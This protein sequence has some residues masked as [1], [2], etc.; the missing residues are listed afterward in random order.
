[1]DINKNFAKVPAYI[2]KYHR[3]EEDEIRRQIDR[4]EMLKIPVG[5][6]IVAEP[7]RRQTLE[8]LYEANDDIV[9]LLE[10]MPIS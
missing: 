7:E 10:R 3:E 5:M 6:R 9:G 1:M 8:H 2:D 4:E